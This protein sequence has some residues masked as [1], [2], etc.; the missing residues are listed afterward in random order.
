MADQTRIEAIGNT[1]DIV[2]C[3]HLGCETFGKQ[4]RDGIWDSMNP[5]WDTPD[6]KARG[7]ERMVQR[8]SSITK[9]R[10]GDPNTIFLKATLPDPEREG[11]RIMAGMAI[12]VQASVV[13]GYGEA[14]VEDFSKAMDLES[15]YPGNTKEQLYLCQ[16]DRGFHR[17]RV[18]VVKEKA[19]ASPPAVMV[20]D[21]CTVSPAFQRRGI[22]AQLVQWG[23]DEAQRRGRLECLTE[24]SSMGRTVYA[25]LGFIAE[26]PEIDYGVDAEF[27]DR[28]RP[29]NLFMRIQSPA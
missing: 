26:E 8:W 18:E 27:A 11:E 7:A 16:L 14:P 12:W 20:L 13:E 24:A 9:D 29:S 2:Q 4:T 1:T 5:A 22:A 25:K 17:R 3:F 15:I 6:G 23:L 28:N 21:C 10:N 19:T